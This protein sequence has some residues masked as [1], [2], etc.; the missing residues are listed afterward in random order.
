MK[1]CPLDV[2]CTSK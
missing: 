2:K 1:I